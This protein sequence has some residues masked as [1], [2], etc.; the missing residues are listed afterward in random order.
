M[1]KHSELN[2][3]VNSHDGNKKINRPEY[4]IMK[5]KIIKT[6]FSETHLPINGWIQGCV[7]CEIPTSK[8]IVIKVIKK[9][10]RIYE[11]CAHFCYVCKKIVNSNEEKKNE[12]FNSAIK[13][14]KE[15]YPLI[16]VGT[17]I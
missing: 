7:H 16:F 11:L 6:I 17:N 10:N 12:I 13:D 9:K 5:K 15:L 14:F 3:I 1:N 2:I 8:T 4:N